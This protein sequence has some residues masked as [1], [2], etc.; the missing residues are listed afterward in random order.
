MRLHPE[1]GYQM[2]AG[3]P[4]LD[5]PREIV[6]SHQER[7]DGTGYPRRLKGEQIP[8]GARVFAVADTY[9]AMTST[10]PY[11][12]GLPY[13]V[14][15]KEII[16]WSGRQ[17]DPDVVTAFLNI[18]SERWLEIREEVSRRIHDAEVKTGGYRF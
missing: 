2:L 11:R 18:S 9:D 17:F 14:A 8:L 10:R 4:F 1:L 7:Y 16:D 12:T 13:D 15:R 5:T 3:I 6:L